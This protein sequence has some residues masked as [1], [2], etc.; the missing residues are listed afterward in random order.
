MFDYRLRKSLILLLLE[1]SSEILFLAFTT[2][3][4]SGISNAGVIAVINYAIANLQAFVSDNAQRIYEVKPPQKTVTL[5][6]IPCKVPAMF[7]EVVPM[8]ANQELPWS[9]T[10]VKI[11]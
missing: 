1:N 6:P 11:G 3:V 7:G 2:S 10:D 8:F 9:I 4:I 5:K